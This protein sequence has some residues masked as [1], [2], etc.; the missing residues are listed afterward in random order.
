LTKDA[1]SGNYGNQTQAASSTACSGIR[2]I[3]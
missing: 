2:A 1:F 3:T